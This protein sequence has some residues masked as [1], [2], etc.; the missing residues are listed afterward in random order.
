MLVHPGSG[1]EGRHERKNGGEHRILNSAL[2]YSIHNYQSKEVTTLK[3]VAY[4]LGFTGTGWL[5]LLNVGGWKASALWLI[6]GLW[7]IVQLLRACVKLYF[8]IQERKI[9]LKEKAARYN[10]DI[11]T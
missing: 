5:F 4:I 10:K 7:W 6:M 8:E 3:I 2:G 11:F 9:E 1:S